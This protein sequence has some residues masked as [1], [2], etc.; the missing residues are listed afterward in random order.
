[1]D[2][3]DIHEIGIREKIK[4]EVERFKKFQQSVLGVKT[5]IQIADIDIRNYAKYLL[6]EREV[7]EKRE[8]LGCLKSRIILQEKSIKLRTIELPYILQAW[9]IVSLNISR[10]YPH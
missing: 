4:T 8:L 3:I 1:M 2:T 5:K 10:S 6:H 9:K 7:I